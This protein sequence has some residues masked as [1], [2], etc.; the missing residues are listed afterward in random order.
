[1]AKKQID[2]TP[3]KRKDS[4]SVITQEDLRVYSRETG[5]TVADL[6]DEF[7]DSL[8]I[9]AL[10]EKSR[11]F[12]IYAYLKEIGLLTSVEAYRA[13]VCKSP[14]Q[15]KEAS[16]STGYHS[17]IRRN[18]DIKPYIEHLTKLALERDGF[19][20]DRIVGEEM[21]I[22]YSDITKYLD[23]DGTIALSRLHTLPGNVRRAIKAYE[24]V[25]SVDVNGSNV[26]KVKIQLWDKG[27]A[28]GRLQKIKGMHAP[29]R[30]EISGPGGGPIQ[31]AAVNINFDR[32]SLEELEMMEKLFCKD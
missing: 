18:A 1:M 17:Y 16:A 2:T 27:Q 13:F 15:L 25:Q 29:D 28:L 19:R 14:L 26:E 4:H 23:E 20:A 11:R 22:A 8:P 10:P 5:S 24:V 6:F 3:I 30:H 32:F 7:P 31:V 21:A 12:I 9:M